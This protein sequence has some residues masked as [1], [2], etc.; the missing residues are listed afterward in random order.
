MFRRLQHTSS[1][2][3]SW[4]V[5]ETWLPVLTETVQGTVSIYFISRV[6]NNF[7]VWWYV[8]Y[9]TNLLQETVEIMEYVTVSY[10]ML[11]YDM[12]W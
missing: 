3:R 2:L 10:D 1:E 9:F 11:W 5:I 4:V 12:K 8:W 6:Q 7:A